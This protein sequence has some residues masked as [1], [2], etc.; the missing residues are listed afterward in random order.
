QQTYAAAG[1]F[2]AVTAITIFFWM[3]RRVG[4]ALALELAL[5]LSFCA[6]TLGMKGYVDDVASTRGV[7][8]ELHQSGADGDNILWFP[9]GVPYSTSLTAHAP[10][11]GDDDPPASERPYITLW[12]ESK[13]KLTKPPEL[14]RTGSL[15]EAGKWRVYNPAWPTRMA[16]GGSERKSIPEP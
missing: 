7:L 15:F 16:A 11:L 8:A 6:A 4:P 2:A 10:L 14:P 3:P 9:Q 1:L 12:R 13:G 5:F